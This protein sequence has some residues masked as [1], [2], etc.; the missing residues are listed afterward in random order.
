MSLSQDYLKAQLKYAQAVR[1]G[2]GQRLAPTLI[3]NLYHKYSKEQ[4]E[5]YHQN[6]KAQH[7]SHKSLQLRTQR[8]FKTNYRNILD[9]TENGWYRVRLNGALTSDGFTFGS[10]TVQIRGLEKLKKVLKDHHLWAIY[11]HQFIGEDFSYYQKSL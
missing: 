5:A 3:N 1:R 8:A 7:I 6:Y 10:Q 11:N 4:L 9:A 2:H